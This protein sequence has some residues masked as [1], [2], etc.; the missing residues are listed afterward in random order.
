MIT[1]FVGIDW[2]GAKGLRHP[3][4]QVAMAGDGQDCPMRVNSPGGANW[5]REEV[6]EWLYG[7]A[8]DGTDGAT[9]VG[10]DFAFAHPFHDENAYYPDLGDQPSDPAALW[11]HIDSLCHDA[12]HLYGGAVFT[13]RGIGRYYLSAYNTKAM[14]YRARR[15]RTEHAAHAAG[16]APSLTFKAIGADN[17][18]TGSMAGMRLL[19]TLKSRLGER[20]AIW[21]FDSVQPD[22]VGGAANGGVGGK[23]GGG[24]TSATLILS[25][26]YPSY[27]F[28]R[29]G[30]NP[31]RLAAAEP[32]FMNEA[33]AAY[34]SQGVAADYAPRGP[35]A[36]ESDAVITAA[37]LRWFQRHPDAFIAPQEAAK[38]GWIFG[39]PDLPQG[40][41]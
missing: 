4:I 32:A 1:R 12:E 23:E 20:L 13:T 28:R 34:D 18:A 25:E 11:A 2:S 26:I 3:G 33:L 38:E 40:R 14:M 21:P 22:F 8:T 41:G 15:R 24:A 37:A 29:V 36:D 39:V 31:Q 27:Y 35:D 6:L 17:V 16:L 19:H 10:I 30:L 7:L 5:S 9:F